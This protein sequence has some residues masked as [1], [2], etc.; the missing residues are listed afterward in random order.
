[1]DKEKKDIKLAIVDDHRLFRIGLTRIIE[2]LN[3]SVEYESENVYSVILNAENGKD[4]QN[5]LK[6]DCL[7]SIILLDLNMPY[8]DGFETMKWL[9]SLHPDIKIL[10]ISM[11]DGEDAVLRAL[12]LG[13]S[14]FLSKDFD[15]K[16]LADAL[17]TIIEKGSYFNVDFITVKL[18]DSLRSNVD[19]TEDA[20]PSKLSM[21]EIEFIKLAST[22]LTYQQ[23]ASSMQVAAKT[24]DGYR[25]SVF[26]K[27]NIKNRVSLAMYAVRSGLVKL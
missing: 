7:P 13:A 12:R 15:E 14:G 6:A 16:G 11:M 4:L 8:M 20:D 18:I 19:F 25:E 5:Q 1:M 27:L 17:K 22:E 3:K 2:Q 26:E 24:V 9:Q 21:R 23:I 10:V